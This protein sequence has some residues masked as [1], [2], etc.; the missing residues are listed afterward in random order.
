MI[1]LSWSTIIIFAWQ[2]RLFFRCL[3]SIPTFLSS[4]ITYRLVFGQERFSLFQFIRK[5]ICTPSFA[6]A[7]TAL[8]KCKSARPLGLVV[9]SALKVD[10][11]I[12]LFADSISALAC[13][14]KLL[15]VKTSP[16]ILFDYFFRFVKLS[17][18][19]IRT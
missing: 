1:A 10:I 11:S 15:S 3:I 17:A 8:K 16:I 6:L 7:K 4:V 19:D 18:Y 12:D 14:K 9:I 5:W 2:Q 13:G